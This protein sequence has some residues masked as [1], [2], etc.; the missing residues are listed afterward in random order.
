MIKIQNPDLNTKHKSRTHDRS[1]EG[2]R[3]VAR[4]K[5]PWSLSNALIKEE[6]VCFV[7]FFFFLDFI[8]NLDDYLSGIVPPSKNGGTVEWPIHNTF[9]QGHDVN[10]S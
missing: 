6:P 8:L 10:D 9:I 5:N 7:L 3:E 4:Q 1:H 2:L